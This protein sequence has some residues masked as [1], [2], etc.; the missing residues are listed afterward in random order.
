MVETPDLLSEIK[1]Q[2]SF[3]SQEEDSLSDACEWA[4]CVSRSSA[5]SKLWPRVM[6]GLQLCKAHNLSAEDLFFKWEALKYSNTAAN[7]F[8]SSSS[9]ILTAN[10]VSALKTQLQREAQKKTKSH[11][12]TKSQVRLVHASSPHVPGAVV[13]TGSRI[14]RQPT[15]TV[16]DGMEWPLILD[17][18]NVI[19]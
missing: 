6:I 4:R 16:S 19:Q 12:P 9:F 14:L 2:F 8:A 15:T 10:Q 3:A 1:R 17:S 7:S 11:I 5:L 18:S 13:G